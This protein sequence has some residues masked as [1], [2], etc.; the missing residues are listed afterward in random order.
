MFKA[1]STCKN[2]KQCYVLTCEAP[3]QNLKLFY[4][5]EWLQKAIF[6]CYFLANFHN[7]LKI[8]F[9]N[10]GTL[11]CVIRFF[12]LPLG[13]SGLTLIMVL[14]LE[15]FKRVVFNFI[16]N[17]Y[18]IITLQRVILVHCKTPHFLLKNFAVGKTHLGPKVNIT[19]SVFYAERENIWQR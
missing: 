18:L 19:Y 17:I 11:N 2:R 15:F 4:S 1:Y 13:S 8:L 5:F 3:F 9:V 6:F 14:N 7:F 10:D 16:F 12:T